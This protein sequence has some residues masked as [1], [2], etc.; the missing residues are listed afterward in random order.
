MNSWA[1]M[2]YPGLI[3]KAAKD[4]EYQ[5]HLKTCESREKDYNRLCESFSD[6]QREIIEKYISACE[7]MDYRLMQLAFWY[8]IEKTE[9][10]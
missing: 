9:S 6:E 4:E 7:N 1:D 5:K 8:G 3:E 10:Q 2:V